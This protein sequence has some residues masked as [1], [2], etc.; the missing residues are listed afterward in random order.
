VGRQGLPVALDLWS[1]GG[2]PGECGGL[3]L[4]HFAYGEVAI[5]PARDGA[6]SAPLFQLPAACDSPPADGAG[7]GRISALAWA[8]GSAAV[9][10]LV[11]AAAA[12]AYFCGIRRGREL[13]SDASMRWRQRLLE[14]EG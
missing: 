3:R 8:L 11:A 4:E 12:A 10:V 14:G 5:L 9:V 1:A 6:E 7:D 2:G 13:S